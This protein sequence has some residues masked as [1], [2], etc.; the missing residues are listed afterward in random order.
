MS[1]MPDI[2]SV[3]LANK[4]FTYGMSLS[5]IDR[6]M[7]YSNDSAKLLPEELAIL[8]ELGID[9]EMESRLKAYI[10]DFFEALPECQSDMSVQL[11]KKCEV[12]YYVLW[13]AM[14]ADRQDTAKRVK[15]NKKDIGTTSDIDLAMTGATV[16]SFKG[17]PSIVDSIFTLI[18]TSAPANINKDVDAVF[19]LIKV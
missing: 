10:P 12:P 3:M 2:V 6:R 14:F 16:D 17:T 13:S 15:D 7:K 4:S 1:D 8:R 19:T 5:D 11:N 9:E 18:K